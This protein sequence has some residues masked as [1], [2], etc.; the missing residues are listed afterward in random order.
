MQEMKQFMSYYL[1][2]AIC[3]YILQF[4]L[5]NYNADYKIYKVK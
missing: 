1:K 4:N 5:S 3:K 2:I